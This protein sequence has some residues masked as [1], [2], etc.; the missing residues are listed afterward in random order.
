MATFIE[1][2]L[3][4]ATGTIITIKP[5]HIVIT[6]GPSH[7]V[8]ESVT[9]VAT[10]EKVTVIFDHDV[11]TGS[12]EAAFILGKINR[13]AHKF[14]CKFV[15]SVGVG[16]QW[17]L[18]EVVKPGQIVIGGGRH[19]SIYGAIGAL[20]INVTNPELLRIIQGG[21]YSFVVPES[22]T[23]EIQGELAGASAMDAALA[24]LSQLSDQAKGKVIELVGG[25]TLTAQDKAVIAGMACG[26]GAFTAIWTESKAIDLAL[27]L[28]EVVPMVRMPCGE[29]KDQNNAA[30]LPRKA[31][32]GV[33]LRAGQ[34]GGFTGGTIADLRKAAALMEGKKLAYGF[35]LSIVPATSR[36]YMM[37]LNEGLIEKFIDFNAQIH[38]VGDRSVVW[39]GP[40]VLD[41]GE[42]L[43]TTGLYTYDG[44]MGV[45]GS[46]VYTASVESVMDAVTTKVI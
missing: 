35:R 6:D 2:L 4:A 32:A 25:E 39:Q 15:Q 41:K 40:G 8:V 19:N 7:K 24:I 5:D 36:D 22:V 28:A 27:D 17:M 42:K 14:G 33:A 44:C 45:P 30:I 13:F 46:M 11:P 9:E 1:N 29:R 12:P 16:Y 18:N 34:I 31:V 21:Y 38:A 23:V 20:G 43:I 26:T 37:A 10:P 3:G